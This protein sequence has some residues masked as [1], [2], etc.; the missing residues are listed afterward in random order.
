M[1]YDVEVQFTDGEVGWYEDVQLSVGQ[2]GICIVTEE[3][4]IF[5]PYNNMYY[6]SKSEH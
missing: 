1:T 4:E 2:I 5:I 6:F 3:W